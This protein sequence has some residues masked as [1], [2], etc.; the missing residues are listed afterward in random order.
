MADIQFN[1]EQ[2]F[3]RPMLEKQKSLFVRL[4]I[5][6]GIVSTERAADYILFG[7]AMLAIIFAFT[8]SYF[9]SSGPVAPPPASQI[10]WVAGPDA[11]PGNN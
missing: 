2:G 3:Q 7:I 8:I 9:V 4:I 11:M 5:A 10:I 1:K 6:T